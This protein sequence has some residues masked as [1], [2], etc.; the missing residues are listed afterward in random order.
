MIAP[1]RVNYHLEH[2][3][4]MTV[5]HYK[6]PRFHRL[7]R[8][9]GVLDHACV[10]NGYPRG[11]PPRGVAPHLNAGRRGR[12]DLVTSAAARRGRRSSR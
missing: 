7:L 6:L 2:H 10:A 11:A 1:N 12:R 5:P 9:R 8:E 4:M 3:L